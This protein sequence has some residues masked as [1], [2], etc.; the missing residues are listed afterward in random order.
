[1]VT[2]LLVI[3]LSLSGVRSG[4]DVEVS[5]RGRER[6]KEVGRDEKRA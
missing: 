2:T 1:M 6:K 3:E 5:L 4:V